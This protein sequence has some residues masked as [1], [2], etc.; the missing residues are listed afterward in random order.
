ALQADDGILVAGAYYNPNLYTGTYF[1]VLR[2]TAAGTLDNSFG[3][4]GKISILAGTN[5]NPLVGVEPD[6]KIVVAGS[7]TD[8][9]IPATSFVV[10]RYSTGGVLDSSFGSG[11]HAMTTVGPYGSVSGIGF[12]PGGGIIVAGSVN[13]YSI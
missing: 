5:G 2:Y 6:G 4:G 13:D 9:S 10:E 7:S 1:E 12:Q 3:A 11:G 8:Y